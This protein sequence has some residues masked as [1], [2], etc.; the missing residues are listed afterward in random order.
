MTRLVIREALGI[1][2]NGFFVSQ[3]N[4]AGAQRAG[5]GMT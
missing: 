5:F 3:K 4:A 2:Q 1:K